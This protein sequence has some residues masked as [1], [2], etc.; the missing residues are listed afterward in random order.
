[1]SNRRNIISTFLLVWVGLCIFISAVLHLLYSSDY[2]TELESIKFAEKNVV[3]QTRDNIESDLSSVISNLRYLANQSRLG[4]FLDY[5]SK[6]TL[7][8]LNQAFVSELRAHEGYYRQLRF[9][10]LNGQEIARVNN[11][12]GQTKIVPH[13]ELQNKSDRYYFKRSLELKTSTDFYISPIDLN[14]EQGEIVIPHQPVIRFAMKIFRNNVPRGL[15][16]LNYDMKNLLDSLVKFDKELW[17]VN[18]NGYWLAG[19]DDELE[20]GFMFPDRDNTR[21]QDRYPDVWRKTVVGK[22]VS[23][24]LQ[25]H[26]LFTHASISLDT[27]GSAGKADK[28]V[29]DIQVIHVFSNIPKAQIGEVFAVVKTRY[30]ILFISSVLITGVSFYL[31]YRSS[32]TTKKSVDLAR[33]S[34][35][36]F[37]QVIEYAPDAMVVCRPDRTIVL[38]NKQTERLFGYSR[39]ELIGKQ[40]EML[41][42][43]QKRAQHSE[44]IKSY[45]KT[46]HRHSDQWVLEI[47]I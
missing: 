18:E 24:E 3:K 34:R 36:R 2:E 37:E 41:I 43:E 47:M 29:K 25:E 33:H 32:R 38:V 30:L 10:S 6:Q 20:W 26:G 13:N 14:V 28:P 16:V 17:L 12:H 8:R 4:S 46:R 1:M 27:L 35:L 40:V 39:K 31:L 45:V 19:P 23:Q 11:H 15:L 9:I 44:H 7:R 22:A 21:F 5:P 42:P